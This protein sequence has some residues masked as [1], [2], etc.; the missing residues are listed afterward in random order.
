VKDHMPPGLWPVDRLVLLYLAAFGLLVAGFRLQVP[1]SGAILAGHLLGI[2]L[3][4]AFAL[5]PGLPGARVFRHWYP[6]P[7]VAACYREMALLIPAVRGTDFDAALARWD[8]ALWGVHPTVWL[9][10]VQTPLLTEI[11]QIAYSLFIP[12]VLL[13]AVILWFRRR[14][15]EFRNYAFLIALGFLVSY[16]GYIL[17]PARGP[18]FTLDALQTKPLQGLWLLDPLRA[19]LDVLESAQFDCF[20]SGHIELTVLA[21]WST[22][23]ISRRLFRCYALYTASVLVATVYLRYHYTVDLLAGIGVAAALL[24]AVSR[25]NREG[26]VGLGRP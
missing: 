16:V 5:R 3:I 17:V 18:R 1:H 22:R 2:L 10:R 11:L 21:W 7:Y 15:A 20:P 12:S 9:E 25:L 4:L 26:R 13:V 8:R 14:A 24:G 19:T 23:R 6:L